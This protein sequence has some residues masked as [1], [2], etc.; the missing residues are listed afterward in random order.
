MQDQTKTTK[1]AQTIQE[2]PKCKGNKVLPE[3]RH[4]AGGV[5]FLCRGFGVIDLSQSLPKNVKVT[6]EYRHGY[7]PKMVEGGKW[8]GEWEYV[9]RMVAWARRGNDITVVKRVDINPQTRDEA[10]YL[11]R[12]VQKNGGKV[13]IKEELQTKPE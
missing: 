5:C 6:G 12:W 13:E 1:T 8:L 9:K 2:C 10:A 3:Y 4:Y 7:V 11:Y